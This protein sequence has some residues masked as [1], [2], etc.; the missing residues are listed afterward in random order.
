MSGKIHQHALKSDT[1]NSTVQQLLSPFLARALPRM[2]QKGRI[3]KCSWR[4]PV[5]KQERCLSGVFT[6]PPLGL[7]REL[8]LHL[9]VQH[10]PHPLPTDPLL[11]PALC[12]YKIHAPVIP[13]FCPSQCC[14]S[15]RGFEK[16][17][18]TAPPQTPQSAPAH[19]ISTEK[20][21]TKL[22]RRGRHRPWTPLGVTK[23]HSAVTPALL[24]HHDDLGYSANHKMI[25]PYHSTVICTHGF[26]PT[27][28][29]TPDIRPRRMI[30]LSRTSNFYFQGKKLN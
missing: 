23:V 13:P 7:R 17:K 14:T 19:S 11:C 25:Q 4:V 24:I 3:T 18:P 9:N 30:S 8:H 16:L 6:V 26:L 29:T 5:P 27:T 1:V 28:L 12:S 15:V 20:I 2:G 21:H 10:Q 22:R